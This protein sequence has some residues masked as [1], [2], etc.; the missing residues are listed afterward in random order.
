MVGKSTAGSAATGNSR[1]AKTPKTINDA[2]S[3]VVRTGRR[4]QVSEMFM[5]QLPAILGVR[6][7]TR[8][9]FD[10]SN[11]PSVTTVSPPLRPDAITLSVPT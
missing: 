10:N 8:V 2:V 11:C 4:I 3:S 6:T 7:F 5:D 1:Y 9:P